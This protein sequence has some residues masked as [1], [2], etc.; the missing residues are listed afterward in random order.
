MRRIGYARV[1]SREQAETH[2]LEQQISRLKQAGA[3]EIFSDIESGSRDSRPNFQAVMK[4]VCDR[5][6][7]EVIVTRIDR[8]GR[9]LLS[10][11][12][13]LDE[14]RASGVP[15]RVL[16]GSVDLSTASGRA[17]ASQ[18]AIWA[19][20]EADMLSE[21]TRHGWQHLKNQKR[22][23]N[24]PF[25]YEAVKE[26]GHR[27]STAVYRDTGK[28]NAQIAREIIETFL[29]IGTLTG[30]LRELNRKYGDR[31]RE[32]CGKE[33]PRSVRGLAD[34][35]RSPVLQG[36]LVYY[37]RQS[38]E[39]ASAANRLITYNAHP[40]ERLLSD[41]EARAIEEIIA[42]ARA[43][44]GWGT[45]T[46]HH[47]LSGLI[48]C[49]QCGKG[50]YINGGDDRRCYYQ[51]QGYSLGTCSQKKMIKETV[52]ETE[53][54]ERLIR[55]SAEI[56]ASAST[57]IQPAESEELKSL[58]DRLFGL[59][60][61]VER[62]GSEKTIEMAIESIRS[63]IDNLVYQTSLTA[64]SGDADRHLLEN[65]SDPDFWL[66]L[67]PTEKRPIYRALVEK[68]LVRDGA[69]VEVRLKV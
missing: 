34:W 4:L 16:D 56:A 57:E 66:T 52:V 61:L 1:S 37:K 11:R 2:A 12:K 42:T 17:F 69:V 19:E 25:G 47:P 18:M 38:G 48:R 27:L 41:E 62:F 9:S 28:T 7:D 44:R 33:Y 55:I 13:A 8:L 63:Q 43:V 29:R 10:C 45:T 24:A 31:V 64:R 50:F 59:E 58:R 5:V 30:T 49:A 54:V 26:G 21:R 3:T 36:H 6:P 22:A 40:Q 68:I 65:F 39:K 32:G 53:V 15:L 60:Q 46:P 51:C 67:L 14:F 35:L 23:V 20:F